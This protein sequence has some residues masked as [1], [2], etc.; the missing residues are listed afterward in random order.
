MLLNL[1][2]YRKSDFFQTDFAE[3]CK[4]LSDDLSQ[5]CNLTPLIKV[6]RN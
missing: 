3:K 4:K 1:S 2:N 6:A 5:I